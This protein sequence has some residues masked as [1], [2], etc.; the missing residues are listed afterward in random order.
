MNRLAIPGVAEYKAAMA[1]LI[2]RVIFNNFS[3]RDCYDQ[4]EIS[5]FT[6]S[7]SY[8]G[9]VAKYPLAC[10]YFVPDALDIQWSNP[11]FYKMLYKYIFVR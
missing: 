6:L 3:V 2:F 1:S 7:C 4:V 11:L 9:V 5:D 8:P 10:K